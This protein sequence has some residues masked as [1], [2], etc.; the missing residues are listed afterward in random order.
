LEFRISSHSTI[1]V[2]P[3]QIINTEVVGMESSQSDES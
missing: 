3:S 2:V 1:L